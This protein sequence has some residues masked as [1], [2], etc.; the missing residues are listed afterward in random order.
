MINLKELF[1][2]YLWS[3]K[4][5]I[6][7]LVNGE[8]KNIVSDGSYWKLDGPEL[9]NPKNKRKIRNFKQ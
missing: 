6:K 4:D 9:K 3:I 5:F 8:I 7:R 1:K 2:D